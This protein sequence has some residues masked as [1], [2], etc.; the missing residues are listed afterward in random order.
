MHGH[1]AAL[2]IGERYPHTLTG[3]ERRRGM[4]RGSA[5]SSG[6]RDCFG[7]LRIFPPVEGVLRV[8]WVGGT[9]SVGVLCNNVRYGA[10][11]CGGCVCS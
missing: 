1:G 4:G 9:H 8:V 5:H 6:R 3:Y 7:G 11:G 2:G 10:R